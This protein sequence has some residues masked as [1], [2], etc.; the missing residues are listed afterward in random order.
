M[1]L[2]KP[3]QDAMPHKCIHTSYGLRAWNH[4][5]QSSARICLLHPLSIRAHFR[6]AVVTAHVRMVR[7]S[8]AALPSVMHN[9][10]NIKIHGDAL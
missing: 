9:T 8:P 10:K 4:A 7:A 1:A 5:K 6:R 2:L 3:G